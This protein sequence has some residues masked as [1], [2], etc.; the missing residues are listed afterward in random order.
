MQ[1]EVKQALKLILGT[2]KTELVLHRESW[3]I[4]QE[5]GKQPR[6]EKSRFFT[7][8][9]VESGKT[10]PAEQ[11]D[12]TC[13]TREAEKAV[14]EYIRDDLRMKRFKPGKDDPSNLLEAW[15]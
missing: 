11:T 6:L 5:E 4:V 8:I 1:E 2:K 15:A 13:M 12:V 10:Y 14:Q 7:F 3:I 9:D